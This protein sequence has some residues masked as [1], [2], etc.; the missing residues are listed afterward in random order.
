MP[1]RLSAI[2]FR[3]LQCMMRGLTSSLTV[4]LQV[5]LVPHPTVSRTTLHKNQP[6]VPRSNSRINFFYQGS[7]F[8]MFQVDVGQLFRCAGHHSMCYY[9]SPR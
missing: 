5:T 4:T 3:R 9:G 6:L 8:F 7:G 1:W 2:A